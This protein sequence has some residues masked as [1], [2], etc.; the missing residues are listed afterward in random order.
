LALAGE[1]GTIAPSGAVAV[2]YGSNKAFL[3]TADLYYHIEELQTNGASDTAAA[4]LETYTSF[5]ENVVADGTVYANFAENLAPLGTPEWWLAYYDLTN[6]GYTFAEAET[7]N[8]DGDPHDNRQE[9]IANTDP[10]DSNDFLYIRAAWEKAEGDWVYWPSKLDRLYG[11]DGLSNLLGGA[12]WFEVTNDLAGTGGW[13]SIT[14]LPGL[15]PV[16]YRVKVRLP[17]PR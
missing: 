14:N 5:W 1:H 8:N 7:N 3:V 6:G 12:S 13:L 4:G 10:T 15:D 17:V 9:Q 11:V 16:Y 2:V